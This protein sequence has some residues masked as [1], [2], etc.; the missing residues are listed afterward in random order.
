MIIVIENRLI[1]SILSLPI[2]LKRYSYKFNDICNI[3]IIYISDKLRLSTLLVFITGK[4]IR[5]LK[6]EK[7]TPTSKIYNRGLFIETDDGDSCVPW[8][9]FNNFCFASTCTEIKIH[10]YSYYAETGT[11]SFL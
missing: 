2:L 8:L 6:Y 1:L 9:F 5:Q 10:H 3:S 11:F 4:I 7:Y